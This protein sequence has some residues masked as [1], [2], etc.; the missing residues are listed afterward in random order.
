MAMS[1]PGK[2]FRGVAPRFEG[3]YN[4][5][6]EMEKK[7]SK[8]GTAVS[9]GSGALCIGTSATG[10]GPAAFEIAIRE[11]LPM[12]RVL[13]PMTMLSGGGY[14]LYSTLEGD[15]QGS[16]EPEPFDPKKVRSNLEAMLTDAREDLKSHPG[17][18]TASRGSG[19][20]GNVATGLRPLDGP[21][22]G[23]GPICGNLPIECRQGKSSVER[24]GRGCSRQNPEVRRFVVSCGPSGTTGRNAGHLGRTG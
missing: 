7:V 5:R 4:S 16:I 23:S 17:R 19:A 24:A 6:K 2:P 1:F 12:A 13:V 9:I 21:A 3:R 15:K 11:F 22:Q 18:S 20:R 14:A 8:V 10:G